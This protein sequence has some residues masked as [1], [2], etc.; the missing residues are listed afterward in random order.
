MPVSLAATLQDPSLWRSLAANVKRLHWV[1]FNSEP[2]LIIKHA[3]IGSFPLPDGQGLWIIP[4]YRSSGAAAALMNHILAVVDNLCLESY[5]EGTIMSTALY[6]K[7]GFVVVVHPT[8]VFRRED[9]SPGWVKLVR[10]MQAHPVSIMWRPK[11][12]AYQE[13]KT[14]LPWEGKA[15]EYKL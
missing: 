1:I 5:L 6:L 4:E 15:R 9:P 11:G 2:F 13:G 14:I 10:E 12:G 8:L 3:L 7:Y